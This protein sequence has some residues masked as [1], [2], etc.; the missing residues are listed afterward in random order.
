V[1]GTDPTRIRSVAVTADDVVAA[2]EAQTRER[3]AVVLR[4]TPPF[5]GRMRARL[6]VPAEADAVEDAVVLAPEEL[7]E[8]DAVAPFPSPDDTED[9][10]RADPDLTYSTELHH[11]RHEAAVEGW[12]ASV[13]EAIVDA[14]TIAEGHEIEVKRLG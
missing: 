4:V 9:A 8:T 13:R 10:I 3:R 11:E 2:Y 7:V 1:S 12:R 5:D 6:H 14:V